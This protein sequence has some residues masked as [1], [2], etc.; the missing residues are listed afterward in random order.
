MLREVFHKNDLFQTAE[1]MQFGDIHIKTDPQ[2]GLRAIIAIHNVNLGP[3][4]GGCRCVPYASTEAALLDAMRLARG[5]SYKA[6]ISGIAQGGGKSVLIKPDKIKDREHDDHRRQ[7]GEQ[8]ASPR[9]G[10]I[11]RRGHG[12]RGFKHREWSSRSIGWA[13][14]SHRSP[15]A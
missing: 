5:M 10:S 15:G 11:R 1:D 13:A 6:A 9:L 8:A 12:K 7:Q 3:A 2:T 4:L 14:G